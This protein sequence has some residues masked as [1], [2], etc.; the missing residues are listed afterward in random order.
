VPCSAH[1]PRFLVVHQTG[2]ASG[3]DN[4][5]RS[6]DVDRLQHWYEQFC[7]ENLVRVV[8]YMHASSDETWHCLGC[9]AVARGG[10][11]WQSVGD[12]WYCSHL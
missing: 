12:T 1:T 4:S 5:D 10:A 2:H 8:I 11:R 9:Q 7:A 3:W 6:T